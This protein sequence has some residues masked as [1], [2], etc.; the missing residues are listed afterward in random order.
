MLDVRALSATAIVLFALTIC[1][2]FVLAVGALVLAVYP[3]SGVALFFF[4]K[5]LTSTC[6]R[7]CK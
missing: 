7:D 3:L 1:A 5:D 4:F 6:P 2:F